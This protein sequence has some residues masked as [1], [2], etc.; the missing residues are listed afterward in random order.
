[1]KLTLSKVSPTH[2]KTL[3]RAHRNTICDTINIFVP[4]PSPVNNLL[5]TAHKHTYKDS[6]QHGEEGDILF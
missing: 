4:N 3:R 1:M 5:F 2:F 6:G